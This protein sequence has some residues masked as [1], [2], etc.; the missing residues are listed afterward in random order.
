MKPSKL[1]IEAGRLRKF[2]A[3][4]H[5]RAM[6]LDRQE[7]FDTKRRHKFVG[8]GTRDAWEAWVIYGYE[9]VWSAQQA[10]I[11]YELKYP[12]ER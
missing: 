1:E 7:V 6:L 3:L 5:A 11:E 8:G 2:A 4:L 10:C 9:A 12:M